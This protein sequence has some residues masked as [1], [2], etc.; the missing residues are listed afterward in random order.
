M[1]LTFFFFERR[2]EKQYF[3]DTIAKHKSYLLCV[4]VVVV[5]VVVSVQVLD[6]F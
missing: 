1:K 6:L 2:S 5:V 3:R 4:F